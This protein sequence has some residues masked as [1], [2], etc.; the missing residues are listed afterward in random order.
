MGS[1]DRKDCVFR[2]LESNPEEMPPSLANVFGVFMENEPETP[3]EAAEMLVAMEAPVCDVKD[4][5]LSMQGLMRYVT[6]AG[7]GA[8][9]QTLDEVV[10]PS[11]AILDVPHA[12]EEILGLHMY[13]GDPRL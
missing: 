7:D 13:P 3:S 1:A 8:P 12:A 10:A 9:R 6:S 2:Q 11:C 4:C 5:K